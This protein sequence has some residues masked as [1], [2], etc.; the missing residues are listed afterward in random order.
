M[1]RDELIR[2]YEEGPDR[3]EAAIHGLSDSEL[4]YLP[5]DGGWSP[6]EVVHHT[7]DSELTS[8]IRLRK[9]LAEENA[10]IQGYDEMEFSRRL[11]YRERPIAPSLAAVRAS[12]ATS[13]SILACLNED[14]WSRSRAARRQWRLLGHHL[15]R[16]LRGTLPRPR[17][18]DRT[19]RRR[20]VRRVKLS[21][22]S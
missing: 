3:L 2:R 19:R 7:A 6:R 13:A 4:D 9:L 1:Q 18:A 12:R 5:K 11:H 21:R 10:E 22:S 20:E 8:A 17:G 16:D 15:A 14:D